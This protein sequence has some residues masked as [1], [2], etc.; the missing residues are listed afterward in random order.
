MK[1][2]AD[3]LSQD[4]RLEAILHS[5]L[6]AV[7]AGQAPD[8]DALLGQHPEF[9]AELAAFFADQDRVARLAHDAA[10]PAPDAAEAPTLAPAGPAA[11]APGTR[12]RYFGDYELLEEIARGGMGVVYKARQVSLNRPVALKMIL[13]GQLASPQDVQRFRA[14]AEAVANLKHPNI[15]AIHEV[16]EHE[17]QHF[18]SMDYVEGT[19]LAQAVRDQPLPARRAAV[20]VETVARAIH[21][22]H[23]RGILHRDLKPS[24]VLLDREG[25]PH[26]M[27]FGLAKRIAQKSDL[28][29]TGAILGTP[30]YMPPEQA[31]GNRA[32]LGPAADVYGLGAL[33][34]DLLTGRPPFQAETPLDTVLQVLQNDPVP[35]RLLNPSVPR[36]LETI[37]LKCLS[38]E[39]QRRYATAEGLAEDLRRFLAGEPILARPVGRAERL[40]RW[41]RRNPALAGLT[42]AVASAMVLGT[43]FSAHF[44]L[45]ASNEAR[46]AEG[47]AE[48]ARNQ[49]L[50]A[51]REG[52]RA[53]QNELTAR[54]H[55]YLSQMS[56]AWLSWQAGQVSRVQELLDAQQ[57]NHTGGH[58][59]R[60]FEWHYLER[61]L[62]SEQRTLCKPAAA[63]IA[64]GLALAVAFRPG[65]SQ[66]AWV[67]PGRAVL[68]DARTGQQV[69]AFPGMS[70][71]VF[72]PD[73]KYL[74][75][76]ASD[77]NG[78][79]SITIR[80][81]DTGKEHAALPH[82]SVCAFSP[83]NKLLAVGL[84]VK[85]GK[86][87][88]SPMPAVRLWEWGTNREVATLPSENL[89]IARVAF[90]PDGTLLAG[91]GIPAGEAPAARIWQVA[92][93]RELWAIGQMYGP[94]VSAL[95]FSP[96][97]KRLATAPH[98]DL[99]VRLWDAVTGRPL[100]QLHG[101]SSLITGAVFSS[102]GTLLV[103]ASLDQTARVW[104]AASGRLLRAYRGH[105]AG[106][107][108]LAVSPDNS[109]L[110][111]SAADGSVKLWDA[112]Q[113]QEAQS[114]QEDA[115]CLAFD[116]RSDQLALGV[117]E[118]HWS[119]L[120]RW[121]QPDYFRHPAQLLMAYSADGRHLVSVGE[122][123]YADL[124]VIVRDTVDRK[125]RVLT[126]KGWRGRE[127]GD[128]VE[129]T[130]MEPSELALSA[131]GRLLALLDNNF[132]KG[133]LLWDV[134]A[135]KRISTLDVGKGT[136]TA[137]VFAPGGKRLAVAV[138]DARI[139]GKRRQAAWRVIVKELGSGET[140]ATLPVVEEGDWLAPPVLRFS[141]DGRQLLAASA[142]R[143]YAWDVAGGSR[144]HGFT[145]NVPF[146]KA[147]FSQDC[148][149]LATSGLNGQVDLWDVQA[150]QQLLTVSGFDGGPALTLVFSPDGARLAGGGVAGGKGVV[151]VWD[152]R[153][154][155]R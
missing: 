123:G 125:T 140:A 12:V 56:Q 51:Q 32:A 138:A 42:A 120:I 35:P 58:D 150:G 15:V 108:S 110:A 79:S 25:T 142:Q 97:S 7:D 153:P 5:Y 65:R 119:D 147:A 22:A 99:S 143:V 96:D 54:R 63:E 49:S 33:L 31:A 121:R 44:A 64:Q 46:V 68:A 23:Q 131:D 118:M 8:R 48:E 154:V 127:S 10:E 139:E 141:P 38:R 146:A 21:Y 95:A 17:G 69:R 89:P 67:E 85:G 152:A 115:A 130:M 34:Y 137:V 101:H 72:S 74:A 2:A 81:V 93:Q 88:R 9:A 78:G 112:T 47:H 41:C 52:E 155:R 45:S 77:A 122:S 82:G 116:P 29:A 87:E 19:S 61:L 126:I 114:F 84:Y 57:P 39:P 90:S 102:D 148:T 109:R 62:H 83:N 3:D 59:F 105:T 71:I 37:C 16:G 11:P 133:V 86:G 1:P 50:R 30:S 27:D 151:K 134:N 4:R 20:I 106:I 144:A 60:H 14:E 28:T 135:G 36:D 66:V 149:R 26:V 43:A 136:P 124:A 113:D 13:A 103:T 18:F 104:D 24:N 98:A 145:L 55:L 111:T 75:G 6:Q 117:A 53:R 73:G 100:T 92:T 132:N 128:H 76:I 70:G 40:W 91:S 80:D 107:G 129:V 94:A